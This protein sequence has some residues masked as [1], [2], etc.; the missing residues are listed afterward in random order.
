MKPL[1]LTPA[2]SRRSFM[3]MAGVAAAM[4]IF[5]EAHF[6]QAAMQTAAPA[7]AKAPAKRMRMTFPEGAVLINAN[8]NPLGPC[9]AACEAIAAIA[10]KGGRYDIDGETEKLTNHLRRP[11][12]PQR[13]DTSPSTPAPLSPSTTL[14]SPSPPPTKGFVNRRPRPTKPACT[15]PPRSPEPRS[16]RSPLKAD[17]LPRR[18]G[19]S[20]PPT[21]PPASSTSA[22]PT[23]PP[24]RITS[25]ADIAW[26]LENKPKGS[27]LLVDEA[28]IHLS[29]ARHRPRPGPPPTRTS[30]SSAPSRRSTAW[31]ASAAAFAVGRPDLLEEAPALR[32][33]T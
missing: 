30:S 9:T 25:K 28:Y 17:L 10:H 3:R 11:E 26:A 27:I 22:T 5:T 18:E 15:Q 1:Q 12:R 31:P 32:S 29:D 2:V 6:A 24:A 13:G 20:S 16:P 19:H 4:P 21:P 7:G 23:T 14:S 8:E 33:R